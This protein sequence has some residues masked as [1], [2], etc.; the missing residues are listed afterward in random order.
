MNESKEFTD[1]ERMALYTLNEWSAQKTGRMVEKRM[2]G[3]RRKVRL[4]EC[5]GEER[6]RS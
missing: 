4:K 1:N 6:E 5:V 3:E 2:C